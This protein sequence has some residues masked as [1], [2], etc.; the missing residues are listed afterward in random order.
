[1][2]KTIS[3]IGF[4]KSGKTAIISELVKYFSER[5]YRVGVIKH[6]NKNF[7]MDREGKDS[8]RIYRAGADV[9]VLSPVKMAYQI[10]L[11]DLNLQSNPPSNKFSKK[12]L[13]LEDLTRFFSEYD[14]IIT[15]GFKKEFC[16]GI[17]VAR[18]EKEL[19][20]LID[21]LDKEDKE[22]SNEHKKGDILAVVLTKSG[23]PISPIG[24]INPNM[25]KFFYPNQIE[26]LAKFILS[27]ITEKSD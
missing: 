13:S 21:L 22:T 11:E 19:K 18:N 23:S 25:P 27:I 4:S 7:E 8:W 24:P 26:E 10:H 12:E 3:F 20:K 17:A 14:I 15:E 5:G 1:M 6:T 16:K 2:K 9:I